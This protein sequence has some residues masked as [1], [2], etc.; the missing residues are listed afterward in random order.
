MERVLQLTSTLRRDFPADGR[1]VLEAV[2]CAPT[3]PDGT[4]GPM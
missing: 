2:R 3:N 1:V 4:S